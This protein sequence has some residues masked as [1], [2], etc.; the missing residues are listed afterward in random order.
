MDFIMM[1]IL[2]K[3]VTSVKFLLYMLC[4]FFFFLDHVGPF[5]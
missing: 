1:P 2:S 3:S 4:K 5:L